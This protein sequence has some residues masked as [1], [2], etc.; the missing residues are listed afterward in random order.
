M[1]R[2]RCRRGTISL[3]PAP[4]GDKLCLPALT[5]LR[6]DNPEVVA[7]SPRTLEGNSHVSQGIPTATPS[8]HPE[9]G[10]HGARRLTSQDRAGHLP[11]AAPPVCA[12]A[13]RRRHAPGRR[14]GNGVPG[15]DGLRR[16]PPPSRCASWTGRTPARTPARRN[17]PVPGSCV[18][19]PASKRPAR[20]CA[21]RRRP[22]RPKDRR[23]SARGVAVP[24]A[25]GPGRLG[26]P[27]QPED[28]V[29]G[30][31]GGPVAHRQGVGHNPA[32]RFADC[33]A[34]AGGLE[35]V[36][37]EAPAAASET[38]TAAETPRSGS[39]M[40]SPATRR[41]QE[42]H[43][44]CLRPRP[45]RR[46]LAL[47]ATGPLSR[48]GAIGR[49][50]MGD[51]YLGYEEALQR[52]VAIKV[53]PA[54]LA[55]DDD[56]MRRFHAEATAVAKLTHPNIVPI[57][58]IGQDAG[59]H[60]FAM[61]YV[62]GESLDRLLARADRLGV[63]ETLG[64]LGQCLAGLGAAHQAGLIHRDVKPGNILLDGKTGVAGGRLRAGQDG[65][66]RRRH[67]GHRHGAGHAGLHRPG[68]GAGP[69]RGRPGRSI[70]SGSVGL[71][72][73]QRPAALSGGHAQRHASSTPTRRRRR[74]ARRP[75]RRR[76]R[77]RRSWTS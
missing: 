69:R 1:W 39:A 42:R 66:Q 5:V 50:G 21:G 16:S 46:G 10:P 65:R 57:Y 75:R 52:S 25:H 58:F 38:P 41:R 70:R 17:W 72:D 7:H 76:D 32:E 51:V 34:Y 15:C 35:A 67:D 27:V 19:P 36:G 64:V 73:A 53:L 63:D 45:P 62:A 44:P 18:C 9:D 56:F 71:P 48:R 14:A 24:A 47:H 20:S 55:R 6:C 26:L 31:A 60:F 23:L 30:P 54:E 3:E 74:W 4:P 49:G 43:P 8:L 2:R 12:P 61:R 68:A 13:R 40:S 59:C 28:Q 33:D 77:W 22:R 11:P 29:Q 37:R